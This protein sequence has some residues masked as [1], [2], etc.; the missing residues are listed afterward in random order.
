MGPS[1][2][3]FAYIVGISGLF[4]LDR[5]PSVRTSK[6][7]WLPVIWLWI[8]GSR[9]ISTWLGMGVAQS[10]AAGQLPSSSSLDQLVAGALMLL[11]IS[12]LVQR[13]KLVSSVLGTSWPIALYFSFCLVS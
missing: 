10:E 5:D 7:L 4:Y 2:A 3:L 1:L 12:V 9:P 6:A 8:N 11:G 13:R